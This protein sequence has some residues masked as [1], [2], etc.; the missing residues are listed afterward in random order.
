MPEGRLLRSHRA[1]SLVRSGCETPVYGAVSVVAV[2]G[3]QVGAVEPLSRGPFSP[4]RKRGRKW[5]S[6]RMSMTVAT[7]DVASL[8]DRLAR[9]AQARTLDG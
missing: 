7:G 1:R 5:S 4:S 2:Q 9:A 3:E 6:I 8:A